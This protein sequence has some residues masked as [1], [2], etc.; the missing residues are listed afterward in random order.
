[1][2]RR[3]LLASVAGLSAGCLGASGP[4][5][6]DT[7]TPPGSGGPTTR[8][9][10]R[11]TVTSTVTT[12][13]EPTGDVEY[14]L[15][16]LAPSATT[17]RPSHRFVLEVTA[18]Y[19][20]DAVE[21]EEERT[22]EELVVRDVSAIR[23]QPVR[24]AVE[25]AIRTRGWRSNSLPDGL[26]ATVERVDFFTG[27]A[28]G[29]THTHFGLTLYRTHPDRPPAVE[30]G[31]AIADGVVS[32][33][34][35]GAIEL[36]L[37]NAGRTTRSVFSGSIVPFGMLSAVSVDGGGE[38]LLWRPYES[39]GCVEFTDSGV[40]SCAIGMQTDLPPCERISRRYRVLPS[41]TGR[42]RD[43]TV[44]PGSGRYRATGSVPYYRE[45]GAPQ[46]VLHFEVAF[47]L[48]RTK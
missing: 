36:W 2:R 32:S 31:A 28:E 20:A 16:N 40:T 7:S 46:S 4:G 37:E 18:S 29:D 38:F 13:P 43:R 44:P 25:T 8:N 47:D 19:S 6:I 14:R 12:S 3:A 34:D 33:D 22:G 41:D 1:M 27:V 15:G 39:E 45:S 35:P 9:C 42:H 30:F 23:D 48:E 24:D 17:D 11:G 21:G 5:S 26:A 10:D